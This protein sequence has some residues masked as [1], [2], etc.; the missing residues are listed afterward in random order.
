MYGLI[1][2]NCLLHG[3]ICK[4]LK[5]LIFINSEGVFIKPKAIKNMLVFLSLLSVFY[6][7][8]FLEIE[9]WPFTDWRVF[10]YSYHPERVYVFSL[11][12]E[13]GDNKDEK[14]LRNINFDPVTFNRFSYKAYYTKNYDDLESYIEGVLKG[15]E[16]D[17]YLEEHHGK[18]DVNFVM[19]SVESTRPLKLKRSIIKQYEFNQ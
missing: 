13:S 18:L 12:A 6:I 2:I 4:I 5:K 19:I 7:P 10:N 8:I 1:T 11:E 14:F 17:K 15:E 16:F 3:I 9:S